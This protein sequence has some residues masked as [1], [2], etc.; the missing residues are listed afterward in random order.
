FHAACGWLHLAEG[1]E[2]L[3]TAR[4]GIGSSGVEGVTWNH[5][6]SALFRRTWPS[7]GQAVFFAGGICFESDPQAL[8][9]DP[10]VIARLLDDV[11]AQSGVRPLGT[12][13]DEI[14]RARI[15]NRLLV[16]RPET[17]EVRDDAE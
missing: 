16:L 5:P 7:G 14:A 2:R 10:E 15:G 12:R 11:C 8:F 4:P 13:S 3:G 1:T 17:I 6:V 9:R